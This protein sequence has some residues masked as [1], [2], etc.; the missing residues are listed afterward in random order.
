MALFGAP[1]TYENYVF[2][3]CNAAFEMQTALQPYNDQLHKEGRDTL[4]TRVGVSCGDVLVGNIGS[5]FRLSYTCLGDSVNLSSRL[6]GL[7]KVYGTN[8]MVSEFCYE[9]V[10]D[11]FL[12]RT[13]DVVAVKG[14]V[15]GVKVYEIVGRKW[16][17][18]QGDSVTVSQE[19]VEY[20]RT[21]NTIIED[22]YFKKK[23]G[24]AEK[25]FR[26]F[27]DRYEQD[28]AALE[29]AYRCRSYVNN[30][31]PDSWNGVYFAKD[32]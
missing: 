4:Y 9:I 13:L 24:V 11:L 26:D 5:S 32:K 30:P 29:M 1:D 7:N 23:F 28:S 20:C 3:G 25:A 18:F 17:P 21:Y 6:E 2:H 15:N 19:R 27:A 12:F 31:P 22:L 14:K 8:I 10:K 16:S